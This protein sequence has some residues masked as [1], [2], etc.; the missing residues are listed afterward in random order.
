MLSFVENVFL[1]IYRLLDTKKEK[2]KEEIINFFLV[3]LNESSS[4]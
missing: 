1:K 3:S 4:N 2:K